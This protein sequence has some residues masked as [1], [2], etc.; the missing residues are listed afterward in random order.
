[1]E[2]GLQLLVEKGVFDKDI[3]NYGKSI[4]LVSLYNIDSLVEGNFYF[5]IFREKRETLYLEKMQ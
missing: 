2:K 4:N 5:I 3:T 1:M